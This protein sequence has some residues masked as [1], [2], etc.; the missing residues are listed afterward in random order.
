[1]ANATCSGSPSPFFGAPG[2]NGAEGVGA[3]EELGEAIDR[4]RCHV[5]AEF[6][7]E[8]SP[9]DV[10]QVSG[11]VAAEEPVGVVRILIVESVRGVT[12]LPVL[13][14]LGHEQGRRSRHAHAHASGVLRVERTDLNLVA[15][16]EDGL[17]SPRSPRGLLAVRR[18]ACS[19]SA[20]TALSGPSITLRVYAHVLDGQDT[21][22]AE[23]FATVM[24]PHPRHLIE[25]FET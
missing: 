9:Q 5:T 8:E 22:V 13:V 14:N 16:D 21:E 12:A 11:L 19:A 18:D 6:V 17:K 10:C 24:E 15:V 23:T 25:G 2:H 4:I 1:M 7:V 3:A 20:S